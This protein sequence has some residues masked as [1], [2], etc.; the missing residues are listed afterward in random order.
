MAA[1]LLLILLANAIHP[2]MWKAKWRVLLSP[3]E[4][5]YEDENASA[6]WNGLSYLFSIGT[7]ALLL[8]YL[9]G[10]HEA[11][12]SALQ[13]SSFLWIA[14]TIFGIDLLRQGLMAILQYTFRFHIHLPSVIRHHHDLLLVLAI[15]YFALLLLVNHLSY[16]VLLTLAIVA[17]IGYIGI[18]W[19]KIITT[20]G[21]DLH[22][23]CYTLLYYLHIE[24]VP[25]I[26][27]VMIS[28]HI[29]GA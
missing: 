18:S 4:R 26:A 19:W 7:Y 6:A 21:L 22:T 25:I 10:T 29:V 20:V 15:V 27:M 2:T 13:P 28:A 17:G 11:G 9:L 23:S 5:K 16:P 1:L 3:M 12:L 8:L 14:L 24:I